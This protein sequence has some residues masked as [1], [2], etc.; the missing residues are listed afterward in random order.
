MCAPLVLES[1]ASL[2]SASSTR[3]DGFLKLLVV[4]PSKYLGN[5]VIAM[6]AVA[7]LLDRSPTDDVTLLVD[8]AYRELITLTFGP[9]HR[10]LYYPR[11]AL[12]QGSVLQKSRLYLSFILDLRRDR[13][14]VILDID[15]TVVSARVTAM[16]R[17]REKIGPSFGNRLNAYTRV[18]PIERDIQHCFDDFV[19]M[20]N[21]IGTRV[22]ATTY[23]PIPAIP[24]EYW[25]DDTIPL[26]RDEM[27]RHPVACIHP[28]ATKDYKQWDIGK[29]AALADWLSG[30]GWQVVI[31]GAGEGEEARIDDMISRMRTRPVNAHG[32][33]S[34][35]QLVWLLQHARVF[36]GNDSGPMHLAAASGVNVVALFGP[37]E[38]LRWQPRTSSTRIIKGEMPCSPEC[39]PEA[40][41]ND[42]RCLSSLS[43]EQVQSAL[44][45][46]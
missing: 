4:L 21:A 31:I 7:A 1:S 5:M 3:A 39:R 20:A 26:S 41:L 38:L 15:G 23:R 27:S 44:E 40:C 18:V 8:D 6:Q 35:V 30:R 43:V 10:C 36:I 33:L 42:Y 45:S 25:N 28:C 9:G 11:S 14:D 37:T 13:Y 12:R 34:L 46:L 32:K 17:G 24:D 16:A 2:Q 22:E 29:F 19:L